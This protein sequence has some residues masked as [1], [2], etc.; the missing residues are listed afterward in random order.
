VTPKDVLQWQTSTLLGDFA[1]DADWR[2]TG[3]RITTIEWRDGN[4]Q[5]VPS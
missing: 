1:L 4:M 2:Q 5:H 3:H